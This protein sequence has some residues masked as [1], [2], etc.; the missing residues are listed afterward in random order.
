VPSLKQ[1][2]GPITVIFDFVNPVFAFGRL[3]DRRSKLRFN[4]LEWDN[5]GHAN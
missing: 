5:A 4:E 3:I 2:L 1:H